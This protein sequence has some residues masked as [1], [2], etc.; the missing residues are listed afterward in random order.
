MLHKLMLYYSCEM[1]A[2]NSFIEMLIR[3]QQDIDID[4]IKRFRKC[5]IKFK[6]NSDRFI[7]FVEENK[8]IKGF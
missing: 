4:E 2:C 1:L 7:N 8:N 6:S 5:L 3:F